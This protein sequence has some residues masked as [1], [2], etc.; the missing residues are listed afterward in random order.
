[1][2]DSTELSVNGQGQSL[3]I[4]AGGQADRLHGAER[5]EASTGAAG[6]AAV[7][8]APRYVIRGAN[9]PEAKAKREGEVGLHW[10]QGTCHRDRLDD[11]CELLYHFFGSHERGK[12]R[13]FYAERQQY[14]HGVAVYSDPPG[15]R[16]DICIQIPGG[17]IDTLAFDDM[18]L[19][20]HALATHHFDPTRV[21]VFYDDM[22]RRV[23]IE[24]VVAACVRGCLCGFKLWEPRGPMKMVNGE[25]VRVGH[26]VT[27]GCR[28]DN[29]GGKF[30]RVYDKGLESQGDRDCIRWEC[31]FRDGHAKQAW[32]AI[33]LCEE[34]PKLA[35]V[36]ASLIGGA[37]GFVDKDSGDRL[38]RRKLVG[39][40]AEMLERLGKVSIRVKRVCPTLL[41]VS[42]WL[43]K[44]V[45]TSVATLREFFSRQGNP[46]GFNQ[47]LAGLIRD[48]QR[49]MR[50]RHENMIREAL[51]AL[52][53]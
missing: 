43:L 19:L 47:F 7:G 40:W 16:E 52:A 42:D 9:S 25:N 22:E 3:E 13:Y 37:I 44:Q 20:C 26:G 34:L 31:E 6:L 48:G 24:T 32:A 51:N 17:A 53:C 45:S 30:F 49:H 5:P 4:A 21:D 15:G 50:N 10:I 28:G 14:P 38:S 8:N 33:V 39:W 1:M 23:P 12:G 11:V 27:F 46:A 36:L 2:E 35:Q 29:G 18:L 41:A